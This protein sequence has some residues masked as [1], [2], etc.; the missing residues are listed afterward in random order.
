MFDQN[1]TFVIYV[2]LG[3]VGG[4]IIGLIMSLLLG[5]FALW[6]SLFAAIGSLIGLA[7]FYYIKSKY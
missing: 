6:M 7:V 5:N 4:G 2:A 3:I 1:K